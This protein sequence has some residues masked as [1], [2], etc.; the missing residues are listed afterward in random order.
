MTE[1]LIVDHVTRERSAIDRDKIPV[2]TFVVDVPREDL[3][4]GAAFPV[5]STEA[6]D[7]AIAAR[8]RRSLIRRCL[9]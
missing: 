5:M 1:Q 3:F 4:P 6:S 7:R 8:L 9:R 2:L